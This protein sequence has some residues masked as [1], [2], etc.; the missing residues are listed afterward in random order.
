MHVGKL[1]IPA[2]FVVLDMEDNS[3]KNREMPMLLGRPFMSTAKAI[4]DV[5]NGKLTMTVLGETVEYDVLES[6]RHPMGAL[7][8]FGIQVNKSQTLHSV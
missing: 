8:C 6:M 2:D 3:D 5:H 4:I 1:I 7:D